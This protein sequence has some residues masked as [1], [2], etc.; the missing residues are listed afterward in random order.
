MTEAQT[1]L[2]VEKDDRKISIEQFND[3][4]SS[5]FEAIVVMGKRTREIDDENIDAYN[6]AKDQAIKD[7]QDV[8]GKTDYF[9]NEK[10]DLPFF[11][12]PER[13]AVSEF[14]ADEIKYKY[15]NITDLS[16]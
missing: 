6:Y 11:V 7:K 8:N 9:K 10:E 15:D 14:L 5:I 4:C 16:K 2:H 1:K 12:K 13:Q 3:K